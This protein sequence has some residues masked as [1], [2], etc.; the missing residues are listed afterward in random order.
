MINKELNLIVWNK[1]V[2]G[3]IY[4]DFENSQNIF[5]N[6]NGLN[7]PKTFVNLFKLPELKNTCYY[8]FDLPG[9][10]KTKLKETMRPSKL[11]RL[12]KEIIKLLKNKFKNIKNVYLFGQ[13]FGAN[14][15]ILL[16]KKFPE[17]VNGIIPINPVFKIV[18]PKNA[19][20]KEKCFVLK[21]GLKHAFTLF[22]GINLHNKAFPNLDFTNNPV[23]KRMFDSYYE[24]VIEST[25][26]NIAVWKS[27][28][29]SRQYLIKHFKKNNSPF[30]YLIESKT[31][32]YFNK[33]KKYLNKCQ[34]GSLNKIFLFNQGDH[35]LLIDWD[36][37]KNI[38][39]IFDQIV[40]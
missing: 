32:P 8:C 14:L 12:I 19:V 40:N 34:S 4:G 2:C 13:S 11:V 16:V 39:S 22:T 33:N 1:E 3:N 30:I 5:I 6:V 38:Y 9:Q 21:S 25:K 36:N 27:M 7:T 23:V 20:K 26:Q 24:G 17:L 37:N 15:I 35:M 10:G 28:R 29:P 31:D 18:T